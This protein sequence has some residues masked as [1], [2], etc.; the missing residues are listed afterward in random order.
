VV[1]ATLN[2]SEMLVDCVASLVADL[3]AGDQLV[4][5][6]A[7]DGDSGGKLLAS[8]TDGTSIEGV[9]LR[10][11]MGKSRQLNRGIRAA[12]G[13]VLLFTDDDVRLPVGWCDAMV[14]AFDDPSVGIAF[15][16]VDG[17][18]RLPGSEPPA[19]PPPGEAPIFTA[20]Y[21]HGAAMAIRA[22]AIRVVG[23]FDERL[24]PGAAAYG[25]EHDVLLR[26]RDAGWRVVIADAP[27]AEHLEWRDEEEGWRTALIYE[28]GAGAFIG[29]SVRRRPKAGARQLRWR[30]RYLRS[31]WGA[32]SGRRFAGRA[33]LAF[34]GGLV[35][36]LRLRPTRFLD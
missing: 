22:T 28:R 9:Y 34:V 2:R 10:S 13:A 18:S 4:V 36:G 23:G 35:Y 14:R 3:R 29:S 31:V 27:A 26:L 17:M 21:A 1:L 11:P 24:G 8:A 30:L 20:G 5:V 7:G 15:G 32:R 12:T 16:P 19:H 6:D 25:E 33:T